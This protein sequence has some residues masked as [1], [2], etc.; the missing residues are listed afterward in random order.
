MATYGATVGN[1]K[2]CIC[3]TSIQANNA[4]MC[5][6]CLVQTDNDQTK[7]QGALAGELEREVTQCGKCDRWQLRQ[8]AWVHHEMESSGLLSLLMKKVLELQKQTKSKADVKVLNAAFIWTEPHS[9]K[10]KIS[11]EIEKD[12]LEGKVRVKQNLDYN[13]KICNRQCN[14][15]IREATDHAWGAM[16][17]IRQYV[18]HKRT[19]YHL[20]ALL[21]KK[22]LHNLILGVQIANGGIDLYFK[23][24]NL[25]RPVIECIQSNFPTKGKKSKKVVSADRKSHTANQEIT[26]LIEILPLCRYW[27]L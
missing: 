19:F 22:G 24:P 16:I 8:D 18:E 23:S 5:L 21:T 15:C 3:G 1:I 27:G 7:N 12:M 2:C 20:E 13:F 14:E 6:Q 17:Q 26:Y 25:A 11:V 10:L 4:A 9:K